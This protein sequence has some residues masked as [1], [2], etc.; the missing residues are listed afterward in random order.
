MCNTYPQRF[1]WDIACKH[2]DMIG[3][4]FKLKYLKLTSFSG[5]YVAGFLKI[6]M[7]LYSLFGDKIFDNTSVK[8]R[9]ESS[10]CPCVVVTASVKQGSRY[11]T[12]S[13]CCKNH[14]LAE[15]TLQHSWIFLKNVCIPK[16]ALS[17][18]WGSHGSPAT[19]YL[20]KG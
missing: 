15:Q 10:V 5:K 13:S 12:V 6:L 16:P 8:N 9:T 20:G 14:V 3:K 2:S 17:L 7:Q 4:E 18:S 11:S 1:I 19:F